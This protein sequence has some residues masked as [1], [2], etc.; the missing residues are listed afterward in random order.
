MSCRVGGTEILSISCGLLSPK[1]ILGRTPVYEINKSR[2]AMVEG[3]QGGS[4][5]SHKLEALRHPLAPPVPEGAWLTHHLTW[6]YLEPR[7]GETYQ[8]YVSCVPLGPWRTVE[9]VSG[10][11]AYWGNGWTL[12]SSL[13][14]LFLSHPVYHLSASSDSFMLIFNYVYDKKKTYS[15]SLTSLMIIEM[16]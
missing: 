10:P 5:R 12:V 7:G 16:R 11:C 3:G 6:W 13:T 9:F 4:P 15:F 8:G 1:T 2:A 14:I